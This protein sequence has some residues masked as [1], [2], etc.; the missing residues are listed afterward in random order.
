MDV[1]WPLLAELCWMAP[2]RAADLP[3]ECDRL[4]QLLGTQVRRNHYGEHLSLQQWYATPEMCTPDARSL[5]LLLP[6]GTPEAHAIAES[7][8][9]D[10]LHHVPRL[11][12]V[13]VHVDPVESYPG[14]YHV[15]FD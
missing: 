12:N 14:E 15:K 3:L 13:I 1:L 4:A 10:L 5:S 9:F 8:R 2:P 6:R 7:V 11:S